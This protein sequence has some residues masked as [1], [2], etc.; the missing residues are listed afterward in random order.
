MSIE[1]YEKKYNEIMGV[2][3]S[4]TTEILKGLK[5][6]NIKDPY[7]LLGIFIIT[8]GILLILFPKLSKKLI[9]LI[10]FS[11]ILSVSIYL[12]ITNANV[13]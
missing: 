6:P 7:L 4:T 10:I 5:L 9:V 3:T 8:I 11:I 1:F 2:Q 13:V 12:M